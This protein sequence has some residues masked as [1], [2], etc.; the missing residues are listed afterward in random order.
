MGPEADHEVEL[1]AVE[2]VWVAGGAP[3]GS[4]REGVL[5]DLCIHEGAS[6]EEAHAC[7]V[8]AWDLGDP[9]EIQKEALGGACPLEEVQDE[10][11]Q[12]V[13][14]V[15]A[16]PQS[17]EAQ[18]GGVLGHGGH[19]GPAASGTSLDGASHLVG[20]GEDVSVRD[21]DVQPLESLL[22]GDHVLQP[23]VA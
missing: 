9:W 20:T 4:H 22:L 17:P 14:E 3:A 2:W 5:E 1:G 16:A 21:R 23:Q 15:V 19:G 12:E 13:A 18:H 10:A 7:R 11:F 6:M 8:E